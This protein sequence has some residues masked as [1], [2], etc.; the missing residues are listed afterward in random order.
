MDENTDYAY[1][2]RKPRRRR[3]WHFG[4]TVSTFFYFAVLIAIAY[5]L[6][7]HTGVLNDYFTDQHV[8]TQETIPEDISSAPAITNDHNDNGKS[9]FM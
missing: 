2:K 5:G 7:S 9:K 4:R 8:A 3:A 1:K 6:L